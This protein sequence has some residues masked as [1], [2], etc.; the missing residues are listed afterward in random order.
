MRPT[1]NVTAMPGGRSGP[2]RVTDMAATRAGLLPVGAV[3]VAEA[4]PDGPAPRGAW[5]LRGVGS[6]H[7]CATRANLTALGAR[8]PG[9]GLGGPLDLLAPS[10]GGVAG[11]G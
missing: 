5:Q 7:R 4:P 3:T 1:G 2:W 8:Q 9:L 11:A 10:S 6:D